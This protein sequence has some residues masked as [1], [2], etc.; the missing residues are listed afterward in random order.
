MS[1]HRLPNGTYKVRYRI[2]SKQFSKNGF[3][4]KRDA[5][6][7][8]V[9]QLRSIKTNTWL[10][11]RESRMTLDELFQEWIRNK[12]I[13]ERT[14][15]DYLEIWANCIH[16]PLG[17]LRVGHLNPQ[18][19]VSW[20]KGLSKRSSLARTRKARSVLSQVM[21]WAVTTRRAAIN[22]VKAAQTPKITRDYRQGPPGTHIKFLT[23][24]QVEALANQAGPYREMIL[25]MA[26]TGLRFGE[27][28]ALQA[29]DIDLLRNR[30]IVRRAW[31]DVRGQLILVPPK[32]GKERFVPLT[33]SI[34]EILRS[35]LE[36]CTS[37]TSLLFTTVTGAPIRYS[38]WRR[39]H[40][41]PAC[42]AAD[43]EG[44][45]PHGLRHTYAALAVQSGANPK[46]LQAT[47]G[48]SDIRLTLDTYGGLF[49][50]DLD[51]L[52]ESLESSRFNRPRTDVPKLFPVPDSRVGTS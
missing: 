24:T 40:F 43:L 23:H 17:S 5:Q 49:G 29:H 46:V 42:I 16:E 34:R 15:C 11:P 4:R 39:N 51:S 25:T 44:F 32:S 12:T 47:L 21:D 14:H 8:E 27:I 26:Y 3:T 48:H 7:W 1:V 35:L 22:P 13:S 38:R 31:S 45:K 6:A 10:D 52:A 37:P 19:V 20:L 50:D 2:G 28:T 18:S 33:N 36:S 30:L 9:E 41:D